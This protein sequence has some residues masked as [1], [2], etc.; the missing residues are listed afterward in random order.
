[1]TLTFKISVTNRWW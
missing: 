1:M